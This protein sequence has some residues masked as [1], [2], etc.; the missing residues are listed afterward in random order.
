MMAFYFTRVLLTENSTEF[1]LLERIDQ[2][3]S[4]FEEE[5]LLEER[6]YEIREAFQAAFEPFEDRLPEN[7]VEMAALCCKAEKILKT[8]IPEKNSKVYQRLRKNIARCRRRVQ[9][10][11]VDEQTKRKAWNELKW[12]TQERA[13]S[14]VKTVVSAFLK[15]PKKAPQKNSKEWQEIRQ[16]LLKIGRNA[17]IRWNLSQAFKSTLR[18]PRALIIEAFDAD[19][20]LKDEKKKQHTIHYHWRNRDETIRN[21]SD[22]IREELE[23]PTPAPKKKTTEWEDIRQ[24]ILDIRAKNIIA[25]GLRTSFDKNKWFQ[26]FGDVLIACFDEDYDIKSK[27]E[28]RKKKYQWRS[29]EEIIKNIRT[30]I[31]ES[32]EN[33]LSDLRNRILSLEARDLNIMGL[34]K[35]FKEN[36]WFRS[37]HDVLIESFPE[38][39]LKKW[40]FSGLGSFVLSLAKDPENHITPQE[41]KMLKNMLNGGKIAKDAILQEYCGISG[42]ATVDREDHRQDTVCKFLK[43]IESLGLDC[44][45]KLRLI[46]LGAWK[47]C[48]LNIYYKGVKDKKAV[49]DYAFSRKKD[50]SRETQRKAVQLIDFQEKLKKID[51]DDQEIVRE[52]LHGKIEMND[53]RMA[54]IIQKLSA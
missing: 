17:F 14:N 35:A 51:K 28:G 50:T 38:L 26:T 10:V 32:E 21:V 42:K 25:W 9:N 48:K 34:S 15:I 30:R 44:P 29:K 23:I 24:K 47:W 41:K 6:F 7:I 5:P 11:I 46:W 27:V 8:F 20:D 43:D 12:D 54:K 52:Y 16:N 36:P 33:P 13:I 49:K 3:L 53:P 31:L 40:M 4:E 45:V 1:S 18:Y 2:A 39:G 22:K 37:H 19:Y